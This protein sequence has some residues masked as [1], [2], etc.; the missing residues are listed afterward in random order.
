MLDFAQVQLLVRCGGLDFICCMT[1]QQFLTLAKMIQG[2]DEAELARI[3]CLVCTKAGKGTTLPSQPAAPPGGT[4]PT[5]DQNLINWFCSNFNDQYLTVSQELIALAL[6]MVRNPNVQ[7]TLGIVEG[8]LTGIQNICFDKSINATAQAAFCSAV[9]QADVIR[10]GLGHIA[11]LKPVVDRLLGDGE[12][13]SKLRACCVQ[14]AP[15]LPV[16]S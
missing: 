9:N 6:T 1:E 15:A 2:N 8:V 16:A 12:T 7:V 11:L 5:C 3:Y 14:G 4:A 10:K 13:L